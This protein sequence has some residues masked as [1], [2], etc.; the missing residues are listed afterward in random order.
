MNTVK[1]V[2]SPAGMTYSS[3]GTRCVNLMDCPKCK[4]GTIDW[5]SETKLQ[6]ADCKQEFTADEL[7]SLGIL[8]KMPK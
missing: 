2:H 3:Q 5:R 6:C 1:N 4:F 8:P 7:R